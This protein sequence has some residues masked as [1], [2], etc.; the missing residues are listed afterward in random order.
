M[1]KISIVISIFP[2][3]ESSVKLRIFFNKDTVV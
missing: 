2:G 3:L 1:D